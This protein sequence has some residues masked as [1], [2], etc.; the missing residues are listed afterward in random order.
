MLQD[1]DYQAVGLLAAGSMLLGV[2]RWR[3]SS[4][5]GW[6][7][8]PLA[9]L[10]FSVAD[11]FSNFYD[12]FLHRP[13]FY[14]SIADV[15]YLVAYVFLAWG[16]VHLARASYSGPGW[17][18]VVEGGIFG[19]AAVAVGWTV[20]IDPVLGQTHD[21]LLARGVD[22]AY[23][24]ADVVLIGILAGTAF[25]A[26]TRVR[27]LSYV[28]LVA[29]FVA[30][31][32]ADVIYA[33]VQQSS[34]YSSGGWIDL[35]WLSSYGL[36]AAAALHPSMARLA[37]IDDSDGRSYGRVR[38]AVVALAVVV[39][40][41][42]IVI[43]SLDLGAVVLLAVTVALMA[44]LVGARIQSLQHQ[45]RAAQAVSGTKPSSPPADRRDGGRGYL[46]PRRRG[47]N[48]VRQL[49]VGRHPRLPA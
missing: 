2:Q 11:L 15:L 4:A 34:K 40:P 18:L 36:L 19:L 8:W 38:V 28:L 43:R 44:A 22:L 10:L 30:Q 7:L 27:N 48:D 24:F 46:D 6:R 25:A 45:R 32:A 14:P 5:R 31:L 21:S 35:M 3:P 12:I 26:K 39:A 29:G 20:L 23:P 41:T 42:V 1:L 33:N 17:G 13:I 9:S 47:P 49:Q 37:A 16:L